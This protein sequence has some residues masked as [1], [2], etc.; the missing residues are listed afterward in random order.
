MC[1]FYILSN[2]FKFPGLFCPTA[3]ASLYHM[4][5]AIMTSL[6][7]KTEESILGI[8]ATGIKEKMKQL[9][10]RTDELNKYS[11]RLEKVKNKLFFIFKRLNCFTNVYFTCDS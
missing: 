1:D 5:C 6:P 10:M 11:E 4:T 8:G 2:S 7:A 9:K 3:T